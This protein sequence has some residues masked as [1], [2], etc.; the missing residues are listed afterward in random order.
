[1]WTGIKY[2]STQFYSCCG[3]RS[4]ERP[5]EKSS[6]SVAE[7]VSCSHLLPSFTV[8]SAWKTN[9]NCTEKIVHWCWH[10]NMLSSKYFYN[11]DLSRYRCGS[12]GQGRSMS[13]N[14]ER[15]AVSTLLPTKMRISLFLCTHLSPN[16]P[17]FTWC[18]V[19]H[20][21]GQALLP[22]FPRNWKFIFEIF[23][24]I[25]SKATI[26]QYNTLLWQS[27]FVCTAFWPAVWHGC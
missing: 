5:P 8:G 26:Y 17:K 7:L 24:K 9:E 14:W 10:K 2:Q 22:C 16:M 27:V 21:S 3:K 23:D 1:M 4:F 12:A 18:T 25:D 15:C 13:P 20:S 11:I 19:Y 6:C